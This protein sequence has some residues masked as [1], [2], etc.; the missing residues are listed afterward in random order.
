MARDGLV[1]FTG[2]SHAKGE[3]YCFGQ[4]DQVKKVVPMD[5]GG[6]VCFDIWGDTVVMSAQPENCT[7][8]IYTAKPDGSGRLTRHT[9]INGPLLADKYIAKA[10]YIPFQNSD[11]VEIDGWILKPMDY[12]PAKK[13][14]AILEV[15][16]GPRMAYGSALM[17]EMQMMAG[18]GYFVFFCNPRGGEGRGEAFADLRGKYGTVDF[19]DLMEF[20]DHVL[21]LYPQIDP[22][23]LAETGGSYGGFMSNWIVGHTDRFAAIASQRSISNW[24][25]D[26]ADSE[27]GVTFDANET[28]ATPWTDMEKMWA[29]SPYRYANQAKTPILFIHS[30]EDYNCPLNQGVEMFVAMKYFGVPSRMCLF[31]GENHS[32]SR[33]G[34]P[35]HRVR[36][37]RE[38]M[39]WFEKYV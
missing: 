25:N 8:D 19:Q 38:I 35:K 4:D 29:Q 18:A 2:L 23:R 37:L 17:H 3:L 10:E 34:K 11:G 33:T 16:G 36:R 7:T 14:P 9:E 5:G 6:I 30:L 1:Y 21:K 22:R 15:H 27:I 12:D 28:D 13:Y 39:D 32:L 26:F 31:E 20:T 24:I